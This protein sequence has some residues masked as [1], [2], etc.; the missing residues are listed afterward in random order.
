[1]SNSGHVYSPQQELIEKAT[2]L[3]EIAP[4]LVLPAMEA[5]SKDDRIR[6]DLLPHLTGLSSPEA[7]REQTAVYLTPF[8]HGE[9]SVAEKLRALALARPT[10]LAKIQYHLENPVPE[11]RIALSAEQQAAIETALA[12]PLSVLT[13]GPGTGK[14]TALNEL[15]G[16]LEQS[17]MSYALA[18]PTGRAAKRLSEATGRPASTI[19]RLLAYAPGVGFEYNADK[20]LDLDMLVVD[21][22]SMLD[23][24]LA[25]HL[26]KAIRPGTHLLLV[27]DVDQLPSVGA[28]DV[29]RD[30]IA[31]DLAPVTR[32]SAIFRQA[33]GSQI[34]TNAHRINQGQ[35]PVIRSD[36]K[37]FFFFPAESAE[38]AANWVQDVVTERIP[39]RFGLNPRDEIQVIAPMYRGAAGV[40]ALN[41]RL[42][43]ALNPPAPTRP[44]R[45]LY[46][47]IFRVGDKVMQTQNNYD[48]EVF[49]GD[50]GW[51]AQLSLEEHTLEIDFEGHPVSYEWTEADQLVLAYAISVHKAQGSEFDEVMLVLP[52]RSSPLLN[53]QIVYTAITRAKKT[54]CILGTDAI[55]KQAIKNREHRVGGVRLT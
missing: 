48:K 3:L 41:L 13:G 20:P 42:Q 12:Y 24:L 9:M 11:R 17:H 31:S 27:G 22:A 30:L 43:A 36:N 50:I 21:E 46:G 55:L 25:N 6:V 32:L 47:Q 18:S 45:S 23:L 4:D 2:A 54:V 26:L 35:M 16:I 53:R 40:D 19:H 7:L 49:N 1:M 28:G 44:E 33:S 34:I 51:V 29:L 39:R 10:R 52:E 38:D 14:T 15:I 5:L 8:Y 37:D